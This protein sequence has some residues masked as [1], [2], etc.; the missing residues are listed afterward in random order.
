MLAPSAWKPEKRLN[1]LP[2]PRQTPTIQNHSAP[3]AREPRGYEALEEGDRN[4]HFFTGEVQTSSWVMLSIL[5]ITGRQNYSDPNLYLTK[6]EK[7][8]I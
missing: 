1:N 8:L 6:R 4:I 5:L 7:A 2:G 3:E